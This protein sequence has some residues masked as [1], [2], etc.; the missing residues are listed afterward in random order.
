M[1]APERPRG[2][3]PFALWNAARGVWTSG[4][5]WF[6]GRAAEAA[7]EFFP[8]YL[9]LTS[10]EWAGKPFVLAD[11]QADDIIRP[12]FGWKRADGTRR[13]RRCYVWVPRK[14]GKTEMA[15]GIALLMLLGDAEEGGEVYSIAADKDQA[16]IVFNKATL[17]A[18]KSEDLQE[19]LVCLKTAIYCSALNASF[20]PLSGS[21]KGKHGMAA[22]GLIG[23][24]IHEWTGGD[25]YQF[26]H[27]SEGNRRQPLEFLIS[28][29]GKKGGYG[30]DVYD[31][32]EK[33]CDGVIEDPET[34]VVIYAA[35][36]EKDDWTAEST[37]F[38]ANPNLGI[39]KKLET[40][41]ADA[42]RA[43]QSPRLEN[44]FKAYHLNIWSEQAVRW[45]P[46]DMADDQG[47]RF[48]WTYCAGPRKW[49][50][51][52]IDLTGKRC[53]SGIDL[54]SISDLTALVHWFP[55]QPGLDVP[56]VV[57]R[58]FKPRDLIE[59]HSKRDRLPYDKWA[60]SG[61]LF[62]TE[63]NV[64]DYAF[65][66]RTL[67]DDAER[68]EIENIGVDR[69][70]ATQTTIEIAQEGLPIEYFQQGFI[71][72]SPPSKELERLVMSN[73]LHHGGHPILDRHARV[74]AVETDPAGN[75]KPTKAKS[76]QRIDG[77]VA[78]VNAIGVASKDV[79]DAGKLTSERIMER[80]GLI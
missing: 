46:I 77:I 72:M 29:A 43:M 5:F 15:A 19:S 67:F 20:K 74:V 45:L 62:T 64:V 26:M 8:S 16:A 44:S 54:S 24:E 37:W 38:K 73:A 22:S 40:M 66:K 27:D 35:D 6:D 41:R 55:V 70:N 71:S 59:E 13:Y 68:F 49:K 36:P 79:G 32:C 3:G 60:A 28:T 31:E 58:F 7:V 33:I 39:S 76:T 21:G 12:L 75:I 53:F 30:A 69:F 4:D 50:D 61:A 25:L 18:G 34:L 47:R 14:N 48:G 2:V 65:L 63:G 23:D 11:W 52:E 51:L 10:G 56:A 17:M 9:R 57:A 1:L 42:R 80:G 78:L